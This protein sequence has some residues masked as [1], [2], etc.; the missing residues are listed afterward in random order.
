MRQHPDGNVFINTSICST[1]DIDTLVE[2][3]DY[4]MEDT[5]SQ[6][7]LIVLNDSNVESIIKEIHIEQSHGG[8]DKVETAFHKKYYYIGLRKAVQ[9]VLE[10][11][12]CMN[13]KK[14]NTVAPLLTVML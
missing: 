1:H 8:R 9:H 4:V 10:N 7:R 6:H 2:G 3:R 13:T 11:C 12:S 5:T 14:N